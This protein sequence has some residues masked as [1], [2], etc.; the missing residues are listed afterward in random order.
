MVGFL[1]F[2]IEKTVVS[3]SCKSIQGNFTFF[4]N[5]ETNRFIERVFQILD[6]VVAFQVQ[7]SVNKV[8][9][10]ILAGEQVLES[11]IGS[12]VDVCFAFQF[13]RNRLI[14]KSPSVKFRDLIYNEK[15]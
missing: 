14:H 8:L 13:F 3:R 12:R 6:L 11:G 5:H 7:D 1:H 10:G 15:F 9:D 2:D 4:G